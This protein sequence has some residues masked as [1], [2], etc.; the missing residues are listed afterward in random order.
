MTILA[1]LTAAAALGAAPDLS[2]L[3][4]YWLSCKDGR[5]V[6]E[7]WSDPRGGAVFG[8]SVTVAR[9]RA[10]W[11]FARIAPSDE[12]LSFFAEPAGQPPAEFAAVE[13]GPAR[14]VFENPAHDFPHRVI[15]AREGDRLT[16]RIEGVVDGAPRAA[17]WVYDRAA[18]NARCPAPA[19]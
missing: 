17:E 2:W 1:A 19:Q 3:A 16:G 5:E 10:S 13:H 6:S 14:I 9:G 18:L 4:G 15:Y 12:G 7:T 8:L 11:E